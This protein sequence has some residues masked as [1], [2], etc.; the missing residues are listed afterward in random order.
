MLLTLAMR[1][2][3]SSQVFHVS[4]K[5]LKLVK[6]C[7]FMRSLQIDD[8]FKSINSYLEYEFNHIYEE[9]REYNGKNRGP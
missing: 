4:P 6:Q 5:I 2:D 8:D 3:V 9:L 1:C 7:R